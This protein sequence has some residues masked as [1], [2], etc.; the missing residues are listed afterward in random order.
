MT[1]PATHTFVIVKGTTFN[2]VLDYSSPEFTVKTITA[3]TKSARARVTCP[4]H[5]LPG[6]RKAFV[7][8]V[9]GM[10]QI[11]IRDLTRLDK[12]YTASV[13]DANTLLLDVDSSQ[14]STYVSGGEL[15]YPTPINLTGYTAQMQIRSAVDSATALVTLT[16]SNG[17]IVLGG[18]AGTIE[19]LITS[20]A[21]AAF[22]WEDA[23]YSLQLTSSGGVVAVLLQGSI[24]IDTDATQ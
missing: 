4:T 21:T 3:V 2:P 24:H 13:V 19:L 20:T 8:G 1:T 17:G 7:S 22:D 12:A 18:T 10:T 14:F 6:A 16:T 11:N 15:V 23:V 5:A 9:V